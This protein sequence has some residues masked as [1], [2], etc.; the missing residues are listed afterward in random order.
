M[1]P[2]S[3]YSLLQRNE[4]HIFFSE[5]MA[6]HGAEAQKKTIEICNESSHQHDAQKM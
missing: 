6:A 1:A 4:S 3:S 5:F 2:V